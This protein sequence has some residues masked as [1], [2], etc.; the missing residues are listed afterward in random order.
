MKLRNKK[1]GV[2]VDTKDY[3]FKIATPAEPLYGYDT[4][5]VIAEYNSIAELNEEW[6]DV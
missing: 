4:C 1:T 5:D 6:E 3:N 2:I